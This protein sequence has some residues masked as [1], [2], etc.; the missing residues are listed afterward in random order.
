MLLPIQHA[1]H[2]AC[3]LCYLWPWRSYICRS[4]SS[5]PN[6]FPSF[7]AQTGPGLLHAKKPLHFKLMILVFFFS[8]FHFGK[9]SAYRTIADKKAYKFGAACGKYFVFYLIEKLFDTYLVLNKLP[10]CSRDTR[11][12]MQPKRKEPTISNI[13]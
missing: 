4:G 1:S 9:S 3:E 12:Q 7:R 6:K 13:E 10:D 8:P 2:E 5:Q 11:R